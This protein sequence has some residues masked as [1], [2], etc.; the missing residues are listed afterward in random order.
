MNP[1]PIKPIRTMTRH[2]EIEEGKLGHH[3]GSADDTRL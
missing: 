1:R 3:R 2:P